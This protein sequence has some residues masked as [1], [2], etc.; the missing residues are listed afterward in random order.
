MVAAVTVEDIDVVDLIELMLQRICGENTRYARIESGAEK[1]RDTGLLKSVMVC[2]LPLI[3]ELCRVER[4]VVCGIDIR[5]L[6][7]QACVHDGQILV[8]K[9]EVQA[10]VRLELFHDGNKL[11]YLICVDLTRVD[12]GLCRRLEFLLQRVT[13][14]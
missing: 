13:L 10:N 1:R 8:R 2:P 11:R 4:L 7:R 6:G 5:S 3:F 14:T 12:D 9:R